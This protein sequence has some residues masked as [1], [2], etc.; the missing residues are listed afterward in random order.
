MTFEWQSADKCY[1][2]TNNANKTTTLSKLYESIEEVKNAIVKFLEKNKQ[3]L[4]I[5]Y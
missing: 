3:N 4:K 5:Y 1:S 2:C